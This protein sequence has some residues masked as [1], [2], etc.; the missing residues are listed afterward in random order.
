MHPNKQKGIDAEQ[1]A[2]TYLQLQGLHLIQR[3]FYSR[4]GEIDLI[5]RDKDQ[6]VFCEVRYRKYN[7]DSAIESISKHKC[8]KLLRAANY[9]ISRQ[10]RELSYRFDAIA[11][12]DSD[13]LWL[14][15]IIF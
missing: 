11:I 13:T 1:N 12:S 2:L 5:M 4:F 15:N 3:N 14:K 8:A 10:T 9:Y 6:V 7:I